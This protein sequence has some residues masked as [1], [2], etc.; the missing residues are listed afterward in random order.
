[1]TDRSGLL[2]FRVDARILSQLGE[3]LV[4][5]RTT[6]LAELVKAGASGEQACS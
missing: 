5:N 1:M 4:A 3:E 2:H 6:A